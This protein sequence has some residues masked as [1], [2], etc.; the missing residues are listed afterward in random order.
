VAALKTITNKSTGKGRPDFGL[1]NRVE[2]AHLSHGRR[3]RRHHLG[4]RHAQTLDTDSTAFIQHLEADGIVTVVG[5]PFQ[6][7]GGW[8][9]KLQHESV[10][11]LGTYIT[12]SSLGDMGIL[13]YNPSS[14]WWNQCNVCTL[15]DREY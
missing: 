13:A 1:A 3:L 6:K 4:L 10:L 12:T 9:V 7:S 15:V 2:W 14:D 11:G 8:W 5:K